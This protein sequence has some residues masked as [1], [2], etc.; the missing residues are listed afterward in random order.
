MY[1]CKGER[2]GWVVG[3][4][5]YNLKIVG[6]IPAASTIYFLKEIGG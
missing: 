2:G 3:F 5:T 6:S 4:L 1:V